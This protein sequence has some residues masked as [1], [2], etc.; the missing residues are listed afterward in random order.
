MTN[1]LTSTF[2]A[3]VTSRIRLALAVIVIMFKFTSYQNLKVFY[4]FSLT[5]SR[6]LYKSIEMHVWWY[7]MTFASQ[8]KH[9]SMVVSKAGLLAHF[10]LVQCLL[11]SGYYLGSQLQTESESLKILKGLRKHELSCSIWK[12]YSIPDPYLWPQHYGPMR[13]RHSV[14]LTLLL[15]YWYPRVNKRCD[16][17]VFL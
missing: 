5:I 10:W 7:T 9:Q 14:N 11:F 12:T 6:S 17:L 13:D 3:P 1:Y 16:S 8:Q 4:T 15:Q 2:W